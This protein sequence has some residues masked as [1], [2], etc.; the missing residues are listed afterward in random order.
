M[1]ASFLFSRNQEVEGYFDKLVE[2]HNLIE[3]HGY[4]D[5]HMDRFLIIAEKR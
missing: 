4:I 5:F 3:Q 1:V 2:I